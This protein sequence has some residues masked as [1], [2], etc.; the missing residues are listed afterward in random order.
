MATISNV[1]I[2]RKRGDTA[3]FTVTITDGSSAIN[4]TGYDFKLSVDP[5]PDPA[6]ATANLFS[7]TVG[8]GITLSDPTNGV[9]TVTL[10]TA[11]ADQE[12]N[13]YFYDLQWT[14]GTGFIRTIMQGQ[15]EVQQDVTK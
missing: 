3:P 2:C 6:D 4:V 7:L 12:P 11:R 5:A 15:W 13:V 9:I 1:D 10:S 14:D 8:D